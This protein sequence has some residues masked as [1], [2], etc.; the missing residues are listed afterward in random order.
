MIK[1]ILQ[2]VYPFKVCFF[3]Y[4]SLDIPLSSE[5]GGI[6]AYFPKLLL[7]NSLYTHFP[8]ETETKVAEEAKKQQKQFWNWNNIL[9]ATKTKYRKVGIYVCSLANGISIWKRRKFFLFIGR[10]LL[11]VTIWIQLFFFQKTSMAQ[12]V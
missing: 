9:Y 2:S 7:C 12:N 3:D 6:L 8:Q 4:F 5:L 10:E 11:E 1:S